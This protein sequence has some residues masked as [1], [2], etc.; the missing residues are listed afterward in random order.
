MR[1]HRAR[2]G[3]SLPPVCLAVLLRREHEPEQL[4]VVPCEF[5]PLYAD[6]AED[7]L[8]ESLRAESRELLLMI[9]KSIDTASA[10]MQGGTI[11][12]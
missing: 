5:L 10:R 1:G 12:A 4:F 3:S 7:R 6:P 9:G 2:A 11:G 8:V